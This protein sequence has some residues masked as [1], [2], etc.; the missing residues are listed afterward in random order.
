MIDEPGGRIQYS[1][2]KEELGNIQNGFVTSLEELTE[3][4]RGLAVAEILLYN[5]K[6]LERILENE[7]HK[8]KDLYMERGMREI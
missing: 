6:D 1:K 3:T 2:W 7:T 8:R 5:K 4:V